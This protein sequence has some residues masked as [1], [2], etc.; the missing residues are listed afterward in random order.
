MS[1]CIVLVVYMTYLL[2]FN[3]LNLHAISSRFRD[4][5]IKKLRQKVR[6]NFLNFLYALVLFAFLRKYVGIPILWQKLNPLN[7]SVAL[8]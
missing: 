7:A 2:V 5:F 3:F 6:S 1:L 4:M 8:I